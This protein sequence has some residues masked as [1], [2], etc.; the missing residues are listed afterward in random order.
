VPITSPQDADPS[1]VL[2]PSE[3]DVAI[4]EAAEAL[5]AEWHD[6]TILACERA[7]KADAGCAEAVLLLGLVHFDLDEPTKAIEILEH[8][9]ELNPHMQEC[10]D[11]LA[12]IQVR[13]G[14]VSEALFYA[15]LATTLAPHPTIKNLLPQRYGTFFKNFETGDPRTY[16]HRAGRSFET[17]AFAEAVAHCRR[18][19]ELTPDDPETLRLMGRASLK[20]GR[21]EASI[22][23]L[24]AALHNSPREA[25]DLLSLGSALR[26]AGQGEEA[27]AC[28]A[29]ALS[30][31]PDDPILHSAVIA[32]LVRRPGLNANRIEA[33]H[34]E[35]RIRHG[36]AITPRALAPADPQDLERPLRIAYLSG[37][38]R[39]NDFTELFEP[40]LRLHRPA[41]IA[42]FCYSDT[43]Y[44]DTTTESLMGAATKWTDIA[45]IDDETVWEILRGDEIDIAVDLS[46][47]FEGGRP[48]V[49]ARRP[50][51]VTLSW[52]GYPYPKGL[53][54]LDYFLTDTAVGASPSGPDSWP[55]SRAPLAYIA[56]ANIADV[57]PL[58]AG[59]SGTVTFGV[60]C[61]L[62]LI[63]PALVRDWAEMLW[64]Q[65]QAA[66]LICNR[67]DQDEASVQRVAGLFSHFGLRTRMDVVNMSDNFTSD[68][69]FY[70]HVD[71]ALDTGSCESLVENCRAL[72]MG[73]PVIGLAG[74]HNGA[75]L[76]ASL[77]AGAGRADWCLGSTRELAALAGRLSEDLGKLADLRATLRDQVRRSPLGDPVGLYGA[78]EAAYRKMWRRRTAD[79]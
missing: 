6:E 76:G 60:K 66:I 32:D 3:T 74:D 19:L 28:H 42:A 12:A 77:L 45:G 47:H 25:G 24:H 2:A 22:S 27:E 69:A 38:F 68:F 34:A 9:H 15:K 43:T 1:P 51:P 8:A 23:A 37:A 64:S 73:V 44:V 10:V 26:A 18:Q 52:L 71:I 67:F 65:D 16:F 20:T 72:W 78:L 17:G 39:Q 5:D 62:T 41:R 50:A 4:W 13:I 11:A 63:T 35:W 49:F 29:A 21:F 75:R 55:L 53:P 59:Q 46:G 36:A 40:I 30:L 48:L 58:P 33:A 57:D 54:G 70:D 61:D 31:A 14:K 7:L 56:P 79:A